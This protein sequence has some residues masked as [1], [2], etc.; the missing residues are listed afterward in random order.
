MSQIKMPQEKNRGETIKEATKNY[1]STKG[2]RRGE[3][4]DLNGTRQACP[5]N[6]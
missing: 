5:D 3:I 2:S 1:L 6:S 4:H